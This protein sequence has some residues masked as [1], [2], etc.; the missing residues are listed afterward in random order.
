MS[1]MRLDF[2]IKM[3]DEKLADWQSK[4]RPD[5]INYILAEK[6]WQHKLLIREF[7]YLYRTTWIGLVGVILGSVIGAGLTVYLE[8]HWGIK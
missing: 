3:S 2:L 8:I 5:S 4:F 1:Q 7:G 6:A